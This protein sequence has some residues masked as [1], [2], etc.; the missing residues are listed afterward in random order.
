MSVIPKY[1]CCLWLIFNINILSYNFKNSYEMLQFLQTI[2]PEKPVIL[3]AGGHN[4]EDTLMMKSLWPEAII[5]VFEPI[6]ESFE[7]LNR[8]TQHLYNIFRYNYAVSSITGNTSFYLNTRDF[9]ASSISRPLRHNAHDFDIRPTT[10]ACVNLNE[11][12]SFYGIDHIDFM[13]LDMKGHELHALLS[14]SRILPSVKVIFTE[15]NVM[16]TCETT[17]LYQDL[18]SFLEARAFEQMWI[19]PINKVQAYVLF[20]KKGVLA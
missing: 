12:A 11:W 20:I 5:H 15:V 17:C 7:N 14:A 3:E 4:G 18:K 10:V 9:G 13:W 6:K 16:E 1:L 19:L 2:L 8:N